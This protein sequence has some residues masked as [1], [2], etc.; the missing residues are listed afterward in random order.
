[1]DQISEEDFSDLESIFSPVRTDFFDVKG[2]VGI[3]DILTV[4][5]LHA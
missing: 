2:Q 4:C 5:L 3:A 1:M